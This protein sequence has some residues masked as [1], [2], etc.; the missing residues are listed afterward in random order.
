MMKETI[1]AF[2]EINE[3]RDALSDLVFPLQELDLNINYDVF[4]SY[5]RDDMFIGEF[6]A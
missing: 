4:N 2:F 3:V 5:D 1:L 6:F